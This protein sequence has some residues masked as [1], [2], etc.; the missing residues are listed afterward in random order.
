[1]SRNLTLALCA[2]LGSAGALH[3]QRMTEQF[4]PIGRSPG[5]S[6]TSYAV[7]GTIEFV[8]TAAKT[9]RIASAQGPVTVAFTD[10]THI[11]IDRSEQGQ[12]A[13]VGSPADLL[14]GRRAEAKF[15]SHQRR[16][17][18]DWIKVAVAPGRRP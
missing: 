12:S 18:A 15:V 17:I 1:M 3:A 8:D 4:I 11:W 9:L 5:V 14:I 16:T 10:T 7:L 2:L 6:G 13:L